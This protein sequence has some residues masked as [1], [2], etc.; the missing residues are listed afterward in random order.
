MAESGPPHSE[1]TVGYHVN[2]AAQ[3]MELL[4][5]RNVD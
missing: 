2:Q 3:V 5:K 4:F 1:S